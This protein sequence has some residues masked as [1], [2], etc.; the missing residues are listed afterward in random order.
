MKILL[1]GNDTSLR[2]ERCRCLV[3]SGYTAIGASSAEAKVLIAD[4]EFGCLILGSSLTESD[5]AELADLFTL[6]TTVN[7]FVIRV[8]CH[9]V[10]ADY[11]Y[12]HIVV[13]PA[14][15]AALL[16]AV[17]ALEKRHKKCS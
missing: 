2:E 17:C 12:A 11:P 1:I 4:Q 5:A 15:P 3:D 8:A 6:M 16:A 9:P 14:N 13:N 7:R 10:A